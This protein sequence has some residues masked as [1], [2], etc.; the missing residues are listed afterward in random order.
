[1]MTR[2]TSPA[3]LRGWLSL[4][5]VIAAGLLLAVF[6]SVT[7]K[8]APADAS[9]DRFASGRALRDIGQMAQVPHP[10]GSVQNARVRDQL[11]L[12]LTRLGLSPQVQRATGVRP[13]G[14]RSARLYSL[15]NI[16]ARLPGTD[17]GAPALLVMSHYDSVPGSPGAADDMAG[18]AVAL[19]V[20]RLLQ[21]QGPPRR[22]VIFAF[23]DGEEA[24]LLGAQA[25]FKDNP[26]ARSAGFVINMETRGGGGRA[27][28]FQTGPDGGAAERLF[29]ATAVRPQSESLA[30]F[31]YSKMPNDTDFS[32]ALAH[33]LPGFNYAFIGRP[34]LYHTAAAAPQAVEPGAVQSLGDQVWSVA[35]ALSHAQA[36]PPRSPGL[37]WFDLLGR[38]VVIYP[39][40][41]G[42]VPIVLTAILLAAAIGLQRP[43]LGPAAT[44]IGL[45][46]LQSIAA[47]LLAAALMYVYGRLALTGYYQALAHAG[48][49]EAA[50][51][52]AALGASLL[53][54]LAGRAPRLP[55]AR[56]VG[57]MAIAWLIAIGLQLAAPP[58]AFLAAWPT[59]LA[60][61]ALAIR[62]LDVGPTA[63]NAGYA[64]A[65]ICC[66]VALGFLL[67]T[68]H[69]VVLG[70]G[71]VMPFAGAALLPLALAPLAP[72]LMGPARVGEA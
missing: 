27:L 1:M 69:V 7:P 11:I 22:D 50:V 2:R 42:W 5:A 35:N 26:A 71:L 36:L 41:F 46:A 45:G 12:R 34:Q 31:I 65:F 68:W 38:V 72:F 67:E 17:P 6:A 56:W 61:M 62:S 63:T 10:V 19:E 3:A 60:A 51:A 49:T 15:E 47:T 58:T 43:P 30:A 13:W 55:L 52:L 24:G 28:M 57:A 18:V 54:F 29:A 48:R 70:V 21:R 64:I 33:G 23:T 14:G 66:A 39:S 37:T 8:G 16:I 53:V 32:V 44:S 20:A 59:L 4:V 25:F 40:A 9:P